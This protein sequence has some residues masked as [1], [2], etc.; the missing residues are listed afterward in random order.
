VD[1]RLAEEGGQLADNCGSTCIAAIMW[2]A[3]PED[4]S[5]YR[6]LLANLGDSRGLLHRRAAD[7]LLATRDQKPDDPRE[8]R[9]IRAAGGYVLPADPPAPARLDGVLALSRAF[10]DGRF[11]AEKGKPQEDQR[12]SALPE[13][14]ELTAEPGDVVVLACDGVF[15]VLQSEEVAAL[16]AR[17]LGDGDPVDAA[18]T[19]AWAALQQNTQDNVTCLVIHLPESSSE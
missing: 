18:S 19:I 13:V 16:A 15:D 11:K 1:R 6:I 12:L 8:K 5:S 7:E 14:Y 4:S 9:R 2:P 17:S 10:G 3:G